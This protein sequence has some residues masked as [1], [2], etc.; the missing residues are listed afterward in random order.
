MSDDELHT[1][2]D[3][4]QSHARDEGDASDPKTGEGTEFKDDEQRDQS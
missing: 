1:G 3:D 4:E 2:P